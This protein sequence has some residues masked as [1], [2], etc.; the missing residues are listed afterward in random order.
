MQLEV[1]LDGLAGPTHHYAGLS[2]GNVASETHK[3]AASHPREAALQGLAKMRLLHSLGLRQMVMPPQPRPDYS[4]LRR[5]GAMEPLPI[6]ALYSSS[7][8]WAA[9][10]ATVR[11][12]KDG[13]DKCL[14]FTPANL[15]STPHRALE[16]AFT[17]HAL[18]KIFPL[19]EH[20]APLPASSLFS[21]E[22]A[23][24]HMRL[25][26]PDGTG[27]HVFV[28]GGATQ[29]Y[30]ARQSLAASQ[31]VARLHGLMEKDVVFAEQ[32]AVAIDAGAF[33]NDVV[34][35][36]HGA[37]LVYHEAAF[38]E[39]ENT[40]TEIQQKMQGSAVF[41]RIP[42]NALPLAN[43]VSSYFFNSQIVSTPEG[44]QI[45]SPVECSED[46]HA[47]A[48]IARMVQDPES[49]IVCSHFLDLRQSMRNGGGP[50]CLRLR[51]TM[52]EDEWASVAPGAVF[53][54]KLHATLESWVK[55]HYRE[56]LKPEDLHDSALAREAWA[57][58]DALEEILQLDG[59][60]APFRQHR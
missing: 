50:A 41:F 13:A 54:E 47:H 15:L 49:P 24:N 1:N 51:V 43:A 29:R 4:I 35:T 10:A 36:S 27:L 20:H 5:I 37:V 21:D 39:E 34:A 25:Q 33:H 52:E 22:G 7:G 8:M 40:I 38:A 42:E 9:N 31:A 11:P 60:Y 45:I 57:A 16:S 2:Y 55:A 58:Y 30:P 59:L 3:G 17:A 28:Y 19:A 14:H 12:S 46:A 53:N 32:S 23:A 44:M 26:R 6:S 56:S 48:L 18:K